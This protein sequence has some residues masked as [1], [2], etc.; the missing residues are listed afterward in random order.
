MPSWNW[1]TFGE[2]VSGNCRGTWTACHVELS[3]HP[4]PTWWINAE[5]CSYQSGT[6][7]GTRG[8]ACPQCSSDLCKT[9]CPSLTTT[10][11][12]ARWYKSYTP[13]VKQKLPCWWTRGKLVKRCFLLRRLSH[14][15]LFLPQYSGLYKRVYIYIYIYAHIYIENIQEYI[16]AV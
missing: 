14:E 16:G 11:P 13:K 3:I 6:R 5:T 7:G 12:T 1:N 15:A 4:E 10:F 9:P 8:G 2:I